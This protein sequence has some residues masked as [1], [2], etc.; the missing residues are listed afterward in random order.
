MYFGTH[1]YYDNF[2]DIT[3]INDIND[4]ECLICLEYKIHNEYCENIHIVLYKLQYYSHCNCNCYAHMICL[5][6]WINKQK[7]C[8]ICREK[9]EMFH[10]YKQYI[11]NKEKCIILCYNI[12]NR[13]T[14]I[15]IF[16]SSVV[17]TLSTIFLIFW[18][19]HKI[20]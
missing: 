16:V 20:Q 19:Y 11:Q 12:I 10:E 9:I 13:V 7:K 3:I 1:N 8:P 14:S 15:I 17:T 6:N 5:N 4:N 18:L 2:D